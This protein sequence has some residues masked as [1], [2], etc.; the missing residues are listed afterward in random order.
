[1]IPKTYRVAASCFEPETGSSLHQRRKAL[2]VHMTQL[3]E[4]QRPDLLILP[5]TVIASGIGPDERWGAEPVAGPTVTLAS[6]M[7]AH[8]NANICVPIIEDDNGVLYNTAVYVDRASRIA[9]LYRKRVPTTGELD[10]GIRPGAAGQAPVVLDGL[11]L[12]TA[13]CFDLNFPDQIWPW[14]ASGIDLLVFP[15]Y[16]YAG[17]LMRHWA[18]ACGVPLVC[19]FPWEAVI[20]D[21]DG[22]VLA[23]AGT[24]TSTV[25][26]GFH[27][28]WIACSLDFRS[29]IYHL[30]FNQDR[31]KEL[32]ARHG[33]SVDV[34][35]MV[36]DGRMRITAVSDDMDLDRLERDLGLVP[37]H[38]YLRDSRTRAE[39]TGADDAV[40][41]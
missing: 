13:I 41:G 40:R 14:I 22:T 36:R 33:A 21:R 17:E 16:T 37:L 4:D 20:Y 1:M 39:E 2:R 5:E 8:S 35:L 27:P 26:L 32:L 31:L 10:Q 3:L 7:A 9:G 30:D 29:R 28:P 34:H 6:E 12:G 11:R 18:V 15:S 24:E 38:K 25:P 23:L 19:A